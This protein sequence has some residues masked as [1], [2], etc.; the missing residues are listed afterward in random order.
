MHSILDLY[1][2]VTSKPHV[3]TNQTGRNPQITEFILLI[4]II[5]YEILKI[6]GKEVTA[7]E[8]G[9]HILFTISN[10]GHKSGE[11]NVKCHRAS[12]SIYYSARITLHVSRK[13]PT[14]DPALKEEFDAI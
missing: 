6:F 5:H 14:Y 3:L 9:R 13:V 10:G 4:Q 11:N 12:T 2:D 1:G 8:V 7:C